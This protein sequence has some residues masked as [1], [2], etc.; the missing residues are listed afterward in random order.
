M[1]TET[2]PLWTTTRQAMGKTWTIELWPDDGG[3]GSENLP[4]REAL[5]KNYH[6]GQWV[7]VAAG[8]PLDGRDGTLLHELV[9]L[10]SK[11][12]YV[13]LK[14]SEVVAFSNDL[15]AFLRGFG[16]WQPFPWPDKGE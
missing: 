2:K 10:A 11:T 6:D 16:L 9:H 14:E 5:G 15:Y 3:L 4:R 8:R 13:R 12:A 7:R 1:E